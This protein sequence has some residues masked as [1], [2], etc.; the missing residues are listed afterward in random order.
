M[1]FVGIEV[2]PRK[3]VWIDATPLKQ[4]SLS[5]VSCEESCK[6]LSAYANG[7]CLFFVSLSKA[8]LVKHP[9]TQNARVI[10]E[11]LKPEDD[12]DS[13]DEQQSK[14]VALAVLSSKTENVKL[15]LML[16]SRLGLSIAGK[17]AAGAVV[18]VV[19]NEYYPE[20][21]EDEDDVG[22]DTGLMG[23]EVMFSGSDSEG[24]SM[25]DDDDESMSGEDLEDPGKENDAN[26]KVV[27]RKRT[28]GL[29]VVNHRSGLKFQDIILGSGKKVVQGRNVA[30]KYILR[31]E[32]GKVVDK[33]EARKPFK[34]RLGVGECVKGFDIGVNGMREGGERHLIVP[35][36]LA[37]GRHPPPG[38]PRN[39]TLYFDITVVKAF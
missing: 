19:G 24:S 5:N 31:L 3:I 27:V 17:S 32:N 13:D 22:I 25:T 39:A 11:I 18:H 35:P 4:I 10:L 20:D 14:R 29:P 8:C 33:A 7:L 37:Y 23:M 26:K 36:D 12:E 1:S 16:T 2:K 34:F 15:D 28:T 21:E 9:K 38:I 30:L 6:I